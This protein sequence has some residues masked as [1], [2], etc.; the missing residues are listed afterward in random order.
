MI[1]ENGLRA[2]LEWRDGAFEDLTG[3][4]AAQ[5]RRAEQEARL[6]ERSP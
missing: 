2:A 3:S 4:E 5:R 6:K 1:A